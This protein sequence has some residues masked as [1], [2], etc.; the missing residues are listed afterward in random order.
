NTFSGPSV[1]VS[2]HLGVL[3][4]EL[5]Q[6]IHAAADRIELPIDILF[7]GKGIQMS[8]E[9]FLLLVGQWIFAG[10]SLIVGRLLGGG[11]L[12]CGSLLILLSNRRDCE[13]G[14]QRQRKYKILHWES[15]E[16]GGSLVLS[17]HR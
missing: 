7:T 5:I 14:S 2:D 6:L 1:N 10:S 4:G 17:G 12:I 16:P 13:R 8:P 9:T 3:R 11:W 15:S